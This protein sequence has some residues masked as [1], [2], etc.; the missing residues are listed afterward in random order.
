[1]ESVVALFL[2]LVWAG[3]PKTSFR[4]NSDSPVQLVDVLFQFLFMF[5][6]FQGAAVAD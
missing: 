4:K 3:M 5:E 1:M 6:Q 2:L